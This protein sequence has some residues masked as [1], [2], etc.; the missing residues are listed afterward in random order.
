MKGN[1][2]IDEIR[3]MQQLDDLLSS[4]EDEKAKRRIMAWAIDKHNLELRVE[5]NVKKARA[6]EEGK[7]KKTKPPVDK[8]SKQKLSIDKGLNLKPK[9][10]SSFRDFVE[11]KKPSN[12]KQKMAVCVYYLKNEL[13]LDSVNI[14]K[15]FTCFKEANW[16]IPGDFMNTL[17]QTGTKGWLDTEDSEDI[18]MSTQGEN[19][20][21]Y[22]LPPKSEK[23]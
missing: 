16:R 3:A 19:L 21:E 9:N 23:K 14:N 6:G 5:E 15:I 8:K 13:S 10:K 20:I 12:L 2:M 17:H 1:K 18:K 11:K 4:L 7:G 22:D